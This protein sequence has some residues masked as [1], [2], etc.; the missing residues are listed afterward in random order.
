[1]GKIMKIYRKDSDL[2]LMEDLEWDLFIF[3]P[4]ASID[5]LGF[6][7]VGLNPDIIGM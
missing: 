6:Q 2:N 5:N 1:M 7:I 3:K 4:E